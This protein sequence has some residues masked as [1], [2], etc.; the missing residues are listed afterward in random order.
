M[1]SSTNKHAAAKSRVESAVRAEPVARA[2]KTATEHFLEY[3]RERP[4]IVA[5]WCV[6]LGFVLGWKL[7]PW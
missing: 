7:K 3:G 5:L 1:A 4:A 6:G 2:T